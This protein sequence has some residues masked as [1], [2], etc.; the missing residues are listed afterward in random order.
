MQTA[1]GAPAFDTVDL[2]P[3][4]DTWIGGGIQAAVLELAAATHTN[5]SM[6]VLTD[7]NENVHPY[8]SELPAGTITIAPTLS[9]LDYPAM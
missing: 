2:S 6:L 9:D 8:I 7:G 1:S 4:G 5:R 3:R